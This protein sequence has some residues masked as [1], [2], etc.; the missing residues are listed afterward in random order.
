MRFTGKVAVVTGGGSGI[1]LEVARRLAAEGA[2][3]V[4]NGR[5]PAKLAAAAAAIGGDVATFAGDIADP[6]TGAALTAE[7]VARF[8]A[9]DILVNNAGVFRPKPFLELEPAEYDWFLDT[10]LKG[11]FFAAQAA[12]RAMRAQGRGG[13][14]VQTGS[15]WATQ[16]IGATPSAAYSAANA[17]V[18][19]MVRNLAIELAPHGIRIN[20]VAPAVVETPVYGTFLSPE[21]VRDVL[22][23]FNAF[24]PIGRNGQ[25]ADVAEAILFLASAQAS[26]ITGA[27]LP[28]DGGVTA[29]RP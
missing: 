4:I 20:A 27:V 9:V 22:P 23:G 5:D 13:V 18:H 25:P 7:A 15:M 29:G 10:I 11:K 6:A 19:A 8:G 12:A 21:Q 2:R 26:W 16:A 3:L 14:I 1:G 24:H 17:G 28:V